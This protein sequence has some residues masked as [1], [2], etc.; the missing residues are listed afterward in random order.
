MLCSSWVIWLPDCSHPLLEVP[1]VFPAH[2]LGQQ[3]TP[4][5][6]DLELWLGELKPGEPVW[7]AAGPA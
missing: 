4:A 3:L 1:A 2:S 6:S 7:E 5:I